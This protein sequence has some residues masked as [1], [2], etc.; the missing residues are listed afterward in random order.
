MATETGRHGGLGVTSATALVVGSVIGTGIFGLPSALAA[1]GPISI[2]AFALVT[3]GAVALALVF[4]RL[5][6]RIPGSGGPYLYAREAFGEFAGFLA[7]WSYWLTA[8]A[9]NAAI[10]VALTGYIEV[11]LNTGHDVMWSIA[12]A[13]G[14][15]WL[16]VAINLL[17]LRS[18]GGAQVVFTVL[19]VVPLVVIA[20][21]GLL[22]FDVSKLGPFNASGTGVGTALASAGAVALFAYL[23]IET[24]SV[25]AGRV[26][27]PEVNVP[28]ATVIGTVLC[29]GLYLLGTAAVFGAVTSADLRTSSAPYSDAA[30][31]LFGGEWAGQV[32]AVSAVVSGLGCLVGWTFVVGEMP[33][34]SAGDGLFP[35]FFAR[36]HRGVPA[37]G[38]ISSTVLATALMILAYTSFERVF[39]TVVLLTVFTAVIPY[40]L[41]AAAQLSWLL[42]RRRTLSVRQLAR[43]LTVSVLALAFSYWSM[44]GTGAE[45]TYFGAFA[46]FLGVPLYLWTRATRSAVSADPSATTPSR[47]ASAARRSEEH[48]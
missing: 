29:G 25:A 3:L 47:Q 9:G 40:L 8:W 15:L 31:V 19:K 42:T 30:V 24:A 48:A 43:D 36:E 21:V 2:V 20:V 18:M 12:I 6:Q 27:D 23:G 11:F 39:T 32:I 13:S 34:V 37:V 41:S 33:S 14:C 4:G 7:A 38:I 22:T 26:R 17:G 46:L 44:L 16:P 10:V 28:R 35:R 5:T 45:A 1:F